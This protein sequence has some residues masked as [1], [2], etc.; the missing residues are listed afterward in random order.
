[1]RRVVTAVAIVCVALAGCAHEKEL[2]ESPE[3]IAK[4]QAAADV[5]NAGTTPF[6][7]DD[8]T[9]TTESAGVPT[10]IGVPE[11]EGFTRLRVGDCIDLPSPRAAFVR[12]I[13]CDRP[14]HGEVTGKIELGDRFRGG[15][16]TP[17]DFEHVAATECQ[18]AFDFYVRQPPP[19]GIVNHNIS[20][21][22]VT[23]LEGFHFVICTA[24]ADRDG[25]VLTGSVRKPA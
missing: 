22:P 17:A 23:W 16:P 9:P 18:Q 7:G 5:H 13:D 14:H 8:E 11:Y 2:R 4:E 21:L 15:P 12:P 20:P 6:V 25:N 24:E 10:T 3:Q 19:P 1:M